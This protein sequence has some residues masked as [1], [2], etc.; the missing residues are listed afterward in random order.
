MGV[1]GNGRIVPD[2]NKEAEIHDPCGDCAYYGDC[3]SNP[4]ECE[5]ADMGRDSFQKDQDKMDYWGEG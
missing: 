1:Y 4:S 2:E 5:Y 3:G